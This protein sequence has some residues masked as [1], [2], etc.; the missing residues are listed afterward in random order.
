MIKAVLHLARRARSR[1]G[2][3]LL[4]SSDVSALLVALALSLWLCYE[5]AGFADILH[6]AF[7]HANCLAV[8]ICL[9]VLSFHMFRL[10]K[11]SW[12]F[13]SLETLWGVV[14]ANSVGLVALLGSQYAFSGE[15]FPRSVIAMFWMLS[16][17]AVGGTRI[18]L[19]MAS[20]SASYGR[21]AYKMVHRDTRPKRVVILGAGPTGARVVNALRDDQGPQYEIVGL[22]DD[23]PDELG[24]YIRNIRVLG[25]LAH[26][27]KLLDERRVDEVL[28]ALPGASGAKI[29]AYVMDCRKR[30]VPVKV[31][32]AV[33]DVLSGKSITSLEEISV[34]DLLRRPPVR[35]NLDSLGNWLTD[36]RVMVTGAGGSIGSELCRQI[37]ALR[38]AALIL[39]GHGENS[40]HQISQELRASFP[41]HNDRLRMVIASVADETRMEHVFRTHRPQVVFHAAAHKHVPIMETNVLEAVQ[42]NVIGTSTVA[43]CCGRFGVE[44]MVLISTDKAVLPS[45]VM[46]A[47]KWLCEEVV[48]NA[49]PIY[50]ATTYVAVRFGNVLGSRGS[51]VPIFH[52]A[53]KR[54]GPVCVTHPEMTRYFMLIPEAVQLVLQAG[55]SGASGDLHLLDMGDPVRIADLASDM[56]RL[57]GFE[58][59]VDIPIIYT[60]MRPGEKLH[61][62]LAAD[63]ETIEPGPCEGLFVVRRPR[64]LTAA[65]VDDVVS[66]LRRLISMGSSLEA[67]N[68]L[69]Q[70]VPD[71]DSAIS[72]LDAVPAMEAA[73]TVAGVQAEARKPA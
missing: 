17:A 61:E 18:L 51:V 1:L 4:V 37:M 63:E 33:R 59:D 52:Q 46:G 28:I 25:P 7:H 56:I 65:E 71:F 31:I 29:R 42:N 9:Y 16:I 43:E 66:D 30:H 60:G 58:P 5:S 2:L 50:P 14:G 45:S 22:L 12:R 70:V 55:M 6:L 47:T 67:R 23:S 62:R 54:G 26:L 20:L 41:E 44:K 32:P 3:Y 34:E 8:A 10:Y 68:L 72:S 15:V 36:R 40:I 69:K 38:P 27:H 49:V 57:C 48:R 64:Y 35:M 39:L 21:S 53:I 73:E 19:R 11:Y 24:T 13:A